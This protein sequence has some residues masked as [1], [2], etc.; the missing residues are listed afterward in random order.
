MLPNESLTENI[1][2]P[3][4]KY[5]RALDDA[6]IVFITDTRGVISYVNKNFCFL[7]K[8]D[9]SELIGKNCNILNST[10]HSK[11]FFSDMWS[12]ISAGKVWREEIRNRAKDGSLFWLDMTIVPLKDENGKVKEY[13][14]NSFDITDRKQNKEPKFQMLFEHS[15][16]GLL[17]ARPDGSFL[18]AN[19]AFC[20]ILGYERDELL[21]LNRADILVAND[22]SMAMALKLRSENGHYSGILQFKR[23]DGTII[24]TELSSSIFKNLKGEARTY[25]C[26]RD[27]TEKLRVEKELQANERRLRSMVEN[28]KDIITLID[29]AG[30][31]IY[32]SPS[33]CNIL[34]FDPNKISNELVFEKLHPDDVATMKDIFSKLIT[35]P[36]ISV[37]GQ[38]RQKH[39][40]GSYKWMEGVGTNLLNDPAVKALVCN[41]RDI[42]EDVQIKLELERKNKELSRIFN[43]IDEVIYSSERS[44]YQ[45]TQ[46]SEACLKIYGYTSAEFIEN[47]SLWY[48]LILPEDRHEIDEL[49]KVL[50]TGV[51][52]K[53]Q[54]RI[55][56][57]DGSIKWI[58]ANVT[59][60]LDENGK[61]I[62]ID[63]VNRDVTERKMWEE[64]L[65]DSEK[66]F[67]A[68]IENSKDGIALTDSE[69]RFLYVSPA[70]ES[71]LG[72]KPEELLGEYAYNVIHADFQESNLMDFFQ[73]DGIPKANADISLKV[74]HKDGSWKWVEA[75]VSMK[76]DDPSVKAVVTNF[77]DVTEKRNAEEA[78]LNSEKRYRALIENNKEGIAL[79]D[80]D[81]KF[82]YI[83]PSVKGILGY[84]PY[85]L[86][87]IRAIDLYHPDD[88]DSMTSMV[89]SIMQNRYAFASNLIR[90]R[91]KDGSWRWIELT[92]TNQ[93]DD[94]VV[95]AM[96]TNFRDVTERKN[97]E[98][99]LEQ[100]NQSL[101]KKVEERT[102]ELIE[103][104]K[105]LESFSYLAAHD[106]Q[107]PLR[108]VSGYA[109]ILQQEYAD[110]LG[111]DGAAIIDIIMQQTRHMTQ[112][113]ADLLNFSRVS[114]TMISEQK[115]DLDEIVH[116]LSD[117]L[118]LTYSKNSVPEIKHKQL[119]HASCDPALIRQVWSNLISNALKYSSKREKPVVEIGREVNSDGEMIFYVKDNGTG[120]DMKNAPKLFQVF[121][122]LHS[123]SEFEG[124]G[125]GLALVKNIV[126]RHGGRVWTESQPDKGATFYFSLPT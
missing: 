25:V 115:V 2:S 82:T 122:R 69:A 85:E 53:C 33:Y 21:K 93:F 116:D 95:N 19:D 9:S 120:F 106:L 36:N 78:L 109:S 40:D 55:K 12:C 108:G 102:Q 70:V 18:E 110:K 89:Q 92:S 32:R 125:V 61:V 118:S 14:S 42:T 113:I 99:E 41:F 5:Q 83:T 29:A 52:G 90:I 126:T 4:M 117:R 50:A 7:S 62:R 27:I 94:P 112:L 76:L 51:I 10:Y 114:H 23:K 68:L 88:I 24:D 96:V 28:G 45:L 97:A 37:K 22:T 17:L 84:E 60:T 26:I 3:L 13:V 107:A 73:E 81:R 43:S 74:L 6:G 104:N 91:H 56:H 46:W 11:Q 30:S 16:E 111:A 59:P 121:Q 65:L 57:K 98:D 105:A 123:M 71:I 119:G 72:Y 124:N 75:S 80:K 86:Y 34:G 66:K 20:R 49:N 38:W 48:D 35:T 87:G 1:E 15:Y 79:T 64:S 67:R 58:E 63:G 39:A 47:Q 101:E 31:I 100:L 44:P 8:Y 103:S 77:R 54:Y